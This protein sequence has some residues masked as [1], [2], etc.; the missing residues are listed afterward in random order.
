VLTT[1]QTRDLAIIDAD[2]RQQVDR[3]VAHVPRTR[4]NTFSASTSRMGC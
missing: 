4:L 2:T 3:A 1:N